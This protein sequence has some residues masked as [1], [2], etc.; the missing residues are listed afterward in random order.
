MTSTLAH[1]LRRKVERRCK[2]RVNGRIHIDLWD[3]LM[4]KKNWSTPF[5]EPIE[6]SIVPPIYL[7]FE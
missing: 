7:A 3:S 2:V 1:T 4:S 6:R 5:I